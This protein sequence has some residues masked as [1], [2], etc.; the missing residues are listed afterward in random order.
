MGHK[1]EV[2]ISSCPSDRDFANRFGDFFVK[3]KIT[4]IRDNISALNNTTNENIMMTADI[5][6]DGQPM[7]TFTPVTQEEV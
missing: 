2:I 1:S 6:F 5:K 3:N 4:T 7:T